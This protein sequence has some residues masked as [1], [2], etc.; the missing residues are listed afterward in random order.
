MLCE[1]LSNV[2]EF[3]KVERSEVE[4]KQARKHSYELC[5][6]EA[7]EDDGL[8]YSFTDRDNL[9]IEEGSWIEIKSD[10]F[11]LYGTMWFSEKRKRFYLITETRVP[12]NTVRIREAD[13]IQLVLMQESALQ[14]LLDSQ[15]ERCA[16]LR[17]II[18]GHPNLMETKQENL[19]FFDGNLTNSQRNAVSH[20]LRLDQTNPFFLIH[21]PPGTGKTT[22]IAEI[23]RHLRNQ[24]KNVLITSHTNVAVDNAMERLLSDYTSS[25][26]GSKIVRL[27]LR[28]KVTNKQLRALVP[29]KDDESIKL[30][31]AQ[32]VGATLSKVSM[33]KMFNKI[34]WNEPFFD[35]VIVD[36]SSMATIPLTLVGILSGKQF[37][38]VGDH[39]QLPPITTPEA[40]KLLKEEYESLFRLLVEKYPTRS[41]M[42]DVQ[43]RSHPDIAEFSSKYFYNGQIQSH[44]QCIQ[45]VLS[46]RKTPDKETVSG[47]LLGGPLVCVN[48]EDIYDEQ[49]KGWVETSAYYG[50][51]RSYFNEYEA[52]V[53]LTIMD[54]LLQCGVDQNQICIVTPYRLQSQIIRRA[55]R[56][57]YGRDDV[58]EVLST[59]SLS[60]STVDSF[61]GKESDVVIY[62][63]TWTPGYGNRSIHI[64]LKNWRRLN[65]ALTRAKKKLIIIG[66]IHSLPEYPFSV[67][68]EFLCKKGKIV[69]SPGIDN[70]S[71]FLNLVRECFEN[72]FIKGE[73]D[74]R[75][76]TK[77]TT[78]NNEKPTPQ[79][80]ANV[81][82]RK[83]P[84]GPTDLPRLISFRDFEEY[85]NVNR[86]LRAHPNADNKDIAKNVRL[87][88]DRVAGFR[89]LI[90][91]Q[92]G[93]EHQEPSSGGPKQ[94]EIEGS[95]NPEETS[96]PQ[97]HETARVCPVQV[98]ETYDVTIEERG[99]LGDGIARINGFVCFVP[100]AREGERVTIRVQKI[101]G[102]FA[103]TE[104][105]RRVVET[106]V[107]PANPWR[108]RVESKTGTNRMT[109][110]EEEKQ[111]CPS[112][113][114]NVTRKEIETHDGFCMQCWLKEIQKEAE[115]AKRRS[116]IY[117]ADRAGTW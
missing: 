111:R 26:L 110:G 53:A 75:E 40:G 8:W 72:R 76:D 6:S 54:E 100:N 20:C 63:I 56:K 98:N 14:F 18:C 115:Q 88:I 69:D 32:V 60:A 101:H 61:Q 96:L 62:S 35:V 103:E 2:A 38:L 83:E 19:F 92:A 23:V 36:E 80:A 7:F 46:L 28:A 81:P 99:R 68:S 86:Y 22:V 65:V 16:L 95:P 77:T 113:G 78:A 15:T 42:L 12:S 94:P 97:E 89:A 30:K 24:G 34:D 45:K 104:I 109:D 9:P 57:K 117:G 1:P 71:D 51:Q 59:D 106:S 37:I 87:P 43:Y 91:Y 47:T 29:V 50:Q 74:E 90:M 114:E 102:N 17:N 108:R 10:R 11:T 21:G 66:S 13:E 4:K 70:Y 93:V 112:C 107:P 85:S 79:E 48:T 67:L 5:I 73:E 41:T 52:A 31:T 116:G 84:T 27:G 3:L 82:S 58:G 25:E 49:P 105:V 55:I 39:K 64:A 33:L 44:A